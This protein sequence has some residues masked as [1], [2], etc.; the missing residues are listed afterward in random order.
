LITNPLVGQTAPIRMQST[1]AAPKA[2]PAEVTQDFGAFLQ[3][4]IDGIAAQENK[5]HETTDKFIIGQA[6]VSELMIISEQAKL[7]L[8][9]TTQ[10]RNKVIEAYHEVM[11]MQV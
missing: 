2:T 10:I 5:V 7:S 8:Q 1:I 4:A 11:R 9:L 6:D 3:D